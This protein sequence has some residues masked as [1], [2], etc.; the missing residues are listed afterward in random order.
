MVATADGVM[1]IDLATNITEPLVMQ[2]GTLPKLTNPTCLTVGP[3]HSL[4]VCEPTTGSIW[5]ITPSGKQTLL[6]RSEAAKTIH[7]VVIDQRVGLRFTTDA[8]VWEIAPKD[9]IG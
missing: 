4:Y 3:D 7:G 9:S 1:V 5:R 2:S 8:Q 6:F